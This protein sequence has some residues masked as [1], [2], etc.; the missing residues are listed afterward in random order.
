[1]NTDPAILIVFPGTEVYRLAKEKGLLTDDYWLKKGLC[2]LYTCEHSKLRL[3][4]WSFKTGLITYY[5]DEN[6]RVYDFVYNKIL[7]KFKP[8]NFIRI[9]KRYISNKT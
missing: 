4:W 9:F 6:C 8:D 1:M 7:K 2:P 5:Y 3:W